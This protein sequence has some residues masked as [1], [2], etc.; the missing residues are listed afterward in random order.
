M[1]VDALSR[2]RARGH[3]GIRL[4]LERMRALLA[5]LGDPQRS[6]RGALIGG[7]NGKGSTA[8]MVAS[9]LR[10]GG[11]TTAQS[12]SPHLT[13]YR[14]RILIDG[15]PIGAADLDALLEEVLRASGP[16][17]AEHGPATEF[18]LLTAAAWLRAARQPVDVLVME[19]GLGGR[20][21]ASNTWAADVA[22]ITNVGLDHREYLGDT[23][24]S[25][26][27]EKAAIIKR[28]LPGRHRRVR[29][30]ARGRRGTRSTGR[31]AARGLPAPGGW[32]AWTWPAS[33]VRD[34]RR[35]TAA[36][37]GCWVATRPP[38][39]PS[40]WASSPGSATA[41]VAD[42]GD[43]AVAD[44]LARTRWPGRLEVLELGG[45]TIV[46][47]G[48]HNPDGAAALATGLDELATHLPAGRVVL[49]LAIM[50]DKDVSDIVRALR[51][52]PLLDGAQLIATRVPDSE[53][54]LPPVELAA[55]WT[56]AAP[57]Q[58]EDRRHPR[59]EVVE[60]AEEALA[61]ASEL[62]I[63]ADGPLVISG[64]LYLVGD[65][66]RRLLPDGDAA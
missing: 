41:G 32:R 12:P 6:L 66:R 34:P 14:E 28:R 30:G 64:S 42:V 33:R 18:E 10:A 7:T 20:L 39:R 47:D 44:G 9:M 25:V 15:R 63:A 19:V 2:I 45:A 37:W 13:S 62:A 31:C 60:G 1:P 61:R 8:A 5:E 56:A 38:T 48:A 29:L 11:Y 4:G 52:S 51:A 16:G 21:D 27:A 17:E 54:S 50:S 46:L 40:P 55:A 3:I 43:A 22:A 23:V 49:L 36:S 24:R 59:P 35:G 26:A 53:R 65:V 58:H 57:V